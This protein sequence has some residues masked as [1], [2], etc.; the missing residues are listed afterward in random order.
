MEND[1]FLMS[2][3]SDVFFEK[4]KINPQY[5]L[6]LTE[7][8]VCNNKKFKKLFKHNRFFY[9]KC[10][11][12]SF[13]FVNPRL[14]NKGSSIWYNSNYYNAAIGNEIFR[15]SYFDSFYSDSLKKSHFNLIVNTIVENFPDKN[16]RILD[17]GCAT[18]SILA[19]LGSKYGYSNITGLDLN[20]K[21]VE[22][23]I[24]S[25][26]LNVFHKDISDLEEGKK[27]DLIINTENIEH[28]NSLDEYIN[29]LTRVLNIGGSI[30]IS[31][32][33]NDLRAVKWLGKFGDH[34]VAPNHINYFNEKTIK[35]FFNRHNLKIEYLF[36]DEEPGP[37]LYQVIRS[38]FALSDLVTANPPK[39]AYFYRSIWFFT[40]NRRTCVALK[41]IDIG[42]NWKET[43]NNQQGNIK[44]K[45]F[46]RVIR[47]FLNLEIYKTHKSHL[48]L[49]AKYL[50]NENRE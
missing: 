36:V 12:C 37:T 27:Y 16:I 22:F 32:P 39:E 17:A 10:K 14:N 48:I 29:N 34:F 38:R 24:K 20:K 11:Q 7:C 21:A 6:S 44:G 33:N 9:Y 23:A 40:K 4:G 47:K 1:F 28:V 45:N 8:P 25:R 43:N 19:V 15:N 3:T 41:D 49:T 2:E 5:E 30:V 35:L 31:T 26:S 13:V 18:G 46:K 50:G 42:E